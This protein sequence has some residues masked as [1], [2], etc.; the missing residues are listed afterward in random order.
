MISIRI[1]LMGFVGLLLFSA[2]GE[3]HDD[4]VG[5]LSQELKPG[6][7]TSG[8]TGSGE[9]GG[10]HGEPPVIDS[11]TGGAGGSGNEGGFD[12]AGGAGGGGTPSEI[13]GPKS[14][15]CIHSG[16][17]ALGPGPHNLDGQTVPGTS[18]DING[19]NSPKGDGTY[20]VLANECYLVKL[21]LKTG[22]FDLTITLSQTK[23]EPC[24]TT[25]AM[26]GTANEKPLNTSETVKFK[27][28]VT[29]FKSWMSI[30]REDDLMEI[31]YWDGESGDS[32]TIELDDY[33]HTFSQ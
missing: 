27:K 2:C 8:T 12:Q 20:D 29:V 7:T 26:V 17:Q 9:N 31:N 6:Q 18:G 11:G 22:Y 21:K 28:V 25:L 14:C 16:F 19:P 15:A 3:H 23:V 24:K 30:Q 5:L 4:A 1:Y 32:M 33:N 10:G 13:P